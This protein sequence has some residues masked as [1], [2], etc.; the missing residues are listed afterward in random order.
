MST[1]A[2]SVDCSTEKLRDVCEWTKKT[3]AKQSLSDGSGSM[4]SDPA[5]SETT[6]LVYNSGDESWSIASAGN[7]STAAL[8][9]DCSTEKLR[10]VC[11]WTK[12]TLAK[13]NLS[14]GSGSMSSGPAGSETTRLAYNSGDE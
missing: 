8:S 11:E 5:G 12:K 14:D 13:Q 7:M 1:A 9:V 4:S 6:R 2:L 3:L 10:D